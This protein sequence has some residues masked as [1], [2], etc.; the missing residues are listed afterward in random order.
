L[1]RDPPGSDWLRHAAAGASAD[2]N[3]DGAGAERR[4]QRDP[5]LLAAM[6][7]NGKAPCLAR[8][9]HRGFLSLRV[10]ERVLNH[11]CKKLS[12]LRQ[13]QMPLVRTVFATP[14]MAMG[15]RALLESIEFIPGN[16]TA[17][18]MFSPPN[19]CLR[20]SITL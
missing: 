10:R 12:S 4:G 8:L 3:P 9:V 17:L 5:D 15:V 1:R 19:L 20:H 7:V 2:S 14:A 16:P 18:L 13:V 6:A 11:F